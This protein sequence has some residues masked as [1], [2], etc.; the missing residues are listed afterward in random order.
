[1]NMNKT[2]FSSR[3]Y[4]HIATLLVSFFFVSGLYG[5]TPGLIYKPAANDLGKSVLDS[6][7]DGF[8]SLTT[9]GFSGTDYCYNT[10]SRFKQGYLYS[11]RV[12][13]GLP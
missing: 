13:K 12:N 4:L 2:I 10:I 7:G 3:L 1:M 5:Q 6:N 9:A 8:N 11:I